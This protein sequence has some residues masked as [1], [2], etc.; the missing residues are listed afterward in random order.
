[1]SPRPTERFAP[2]DPRRMFAEIEA[3]GIEVRE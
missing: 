3:C 2:K 1:V